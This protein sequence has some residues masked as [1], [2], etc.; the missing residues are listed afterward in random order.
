VLF[1]FACA[2]AC[3]GWCL[4]TYD[5]STF[6]KN[7]P[8]RAN[9]GMSAMSKN[10]RYR[11]P[12]TD[13]WIFAW[14]ARLC[15]VTGMACVAYGAT[16]RN[17]LPRIVHTV[18]AP[19]TFH[20]TIDPS[21]P[22]MLR[23]NPYKDGRFIAAFDLDC[24]AD[25]AMPG[26]VLID[27]ELTDPAKKLFQNLRSSVKFPPPREARRQIA[28]RSLCRKPCGSRS[29]PCCQQSQSRLPRAADRASRIGKPWRESCSC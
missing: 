10:E 14:A 3:V 8:D 29:S 2:P 6:G 17:L 22:Q 23:I 15:I 9:K 25:P 4:W 11:L 12:W 20:K 19:R 7:V 1:T 18:D 26:N 24:I 16:G 13:R 28:W 5:D 27:I 21:D